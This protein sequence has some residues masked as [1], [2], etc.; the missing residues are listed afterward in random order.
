MTLAES[1]EKCLSRDDVRS[2]IRG[3]VRCL[4]LCLGVEGRLGEDEIRAL[5]DKYI[6]GVV[7][8]ISSCEAAKKSTVWCRRLISCLEGFECSDDAARNIVTVMSC[9]CHVS[10]TR[11]PLREV[12]K[13]IA[14]FIRNLPEGIKPGALALMITQ[15]LRNEFYCSGDTE[16]AEDLLACSGVDEAVERVMV[17]STH[18]VAVKEIRALLGKIR[19]EYPAIALIFERLLS[20]L[21]ILGGKISNLEEVITRILGIAAARRAPPAQ[22]APQ[23]PPTQPAQPQPVQPPVYQPPPVYPQWPPFYAPIYYSF[24]ELNRIPPQPYEPGYRVMLNF[25]GDC[26]VKCFD[27]SRVVL[28]CKL[29]GVVI[30]RWTGRVYYIDDA[31]R[32]CAAMQK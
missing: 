15:K 29:Y 31:D 11:D 24:S 14:K 10:P 26:K 5:V 9:M 4:I 18:I 2:E 3:V 13:E 25:L 20:L 23:P 22:P 30:Q 16:R 7:D 17:I 19:D 12:I 1:I 32:F 28:D 27:A 6:A 8:V 21:E